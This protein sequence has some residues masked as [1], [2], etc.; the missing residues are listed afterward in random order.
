MGELMHSLTQFHLQNSSIKNEISQYY[1]Q[2]HAQQPIFKTFLKGRSEDLTDLT[3]CPVIEQPIL[4]CGANV[5]KFLSLKCVNGSYLNC[6][7]K[8][9]N[10]LSCPVCNNCNGEIKTLIWEEAQI[11]SG[12]IQLKPV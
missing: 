3:V 7:I 11:S 1:C 9:L 10:V 2:F 12:K 5:S 8:K 4:K 6:N